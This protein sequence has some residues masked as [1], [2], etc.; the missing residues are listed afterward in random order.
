MHTEIYFN[1][2]IANFKHAF[3][4]LK[5]KLSLVFIFQKKNHTNQARVR[6]FVI[7]IKK[8]LFSNLK[9]RLVKFVVNLFSAFPIDFNFVS[10][11]FQ[12]TEFLGLGIFS[13]RRFHLTK[14]KFYIFLSS[15]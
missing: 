5:R 7:K 1:K 13:T 14:T 11:N 9:P 6:N 3:I 4:C 15:T 8:K 12:H 10:A 2:W